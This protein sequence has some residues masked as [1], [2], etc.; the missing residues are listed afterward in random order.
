MMTPL[1][2]PTATPAAMLQGALG[3]RRAGPPPRR[4]AA[5]QPGSARRRI[6]GHAME[7]RALIGSGAMRATRTHHARLRSNK[8]SQKRSYCIES[9][10]KYVSGIVSDTWRDQQG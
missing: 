6:N 2:T 10:A 4:V 3:G 1:P 7:P 8:A 9:K 5:E